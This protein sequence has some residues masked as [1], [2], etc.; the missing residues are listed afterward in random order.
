MSNSCANIINQ[1][2]NQVCIIKNRIAEVDLMLNILQTN[3]SIFLG[4]DNR[5]YVIPNDSTTS[6]IMA[7]PANITKTEGSSITTYAGLISQVSTNN[8]KCFVW[9]TKN[10]S[11]YGERRDLGFFKF[12]SNVPITVFTVDI[13]VLN[14]VTPAIVAQALANCASQSS[15]PNET[16]SCLAF[17]T[18]LAFLAPYG[19]TDLT[20]QQA[21]C[22]WKYFM[23]VNPPTPPT[24]PK[25][26]PAE[27]GEPFAPSEPYSLALDSFYVG[28]SVADSTI[29]DSTTN[30]EAIESKLRALLEQTESTDN[31][32]D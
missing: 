21:T 28:R 12:T 4:L 15:L 25:D 13:T 26:N 6:K 19:I 30:N 20:Y 11:Q 29:S 9:S 1:L 31:I 22:I 14:K 27:P 24:P 16:V 10:L 8:D 7:I 2:T 3:Q 5:I 23:N 18:L 32:V 17:S